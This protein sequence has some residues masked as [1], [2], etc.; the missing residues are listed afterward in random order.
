MPVHPK[1]VDAIAAWQ[2][3]KVE[4]SRAG[5]GAFLATP[6]IDFGGSLSPNAWSEWHP[7]TGRRDR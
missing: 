2:R 5:C 3:V 1:I 7:G 6:G 4:N